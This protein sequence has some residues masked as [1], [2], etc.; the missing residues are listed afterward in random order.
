VQPRRCARDVA[1]DYLAQ[2]FVGLVVFGRPAGGQ[3]FDPGDA[4]Q[5]VLQAKAE[6]AATFHQ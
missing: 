2:T 6:V 5:D 3:V 4:L 1:L